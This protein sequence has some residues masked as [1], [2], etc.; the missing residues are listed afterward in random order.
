MP[1]VRHVT[2]KKAEAVSFPD[3]YGSTVLLNV[4]GRGRFTSVRNS[5]L[6]AAHSRRNLDN[7]ILAVA[8]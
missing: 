7:L 8:Q 6:V 3:V 1:G 5:F 4:C 2:I